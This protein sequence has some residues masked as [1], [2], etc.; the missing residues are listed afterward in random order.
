MRM[1]DQPVGS[2][3]AEKSNSADQ[4]NW[5]LGIK[6]YIRQKLVVVYDVISGTG[7]LGLVC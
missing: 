1:E 4:V 5:R 3:R 7:G 6:A 2:L